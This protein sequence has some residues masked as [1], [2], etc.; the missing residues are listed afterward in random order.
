MS[1]PRAASVALVLVAALALASP[2]ADAQQ[3]PAGAPLVLTR[4]TRAV[5]IDGVPDDAG[6]RDVAPLPLTE[7]TPVFRGTPQQRSVIK[8]AYD[9]ENFYA[10][11]WFYDTDPSQIRIN[12][13]YRDRWNGDDAFAIYIDPFNDNQNAKWFGTTASGIRFDILLSDDAKTSNGS[14]DTF[15]TNATTVTDSG[16]FAE[17]RIPLSSIGFRTNANGEAVMGLTVTRQVTRSGERVTFPAIDSKF[18]FRQPSKAQDV[19]LRDVRARKPVYVTPYVLTGA[20]QRAIADPAAGFRT[21]RSTSHEAGLDVKYPFSAGLTL[22]LTLNT[23]FAQVEADDQQ[24][25]LDRFP[26]YFPERR[27]FFQEGSGIFDFPTG[28][29]TLL[30]NSRRI[31]LT[32]DLE[33]VRVLG[34]ARVVGRAGPWDLGVLDM[35]TAQHAAT[36]SENFGVL[37]MRRRVL[38]PFSTAG[39][40]LTS[41]SGASRHNEVIGADATV[42]VHGDQYVAAKLAT[43]IDDADTSSAKTFDRSLLDLK[44][45]RRVQRGLQYQAQ[46]THSGRDYNPELG[47]MPRRDFTMA[48]IAGN[49]FIFTSDKSMFRRVFPGALSFS[50]FRNADHALESGTSAFWLQWDTKAGGGGWIEPKRFHENVTTPFTIGKGI[51]IPAGIYDFADL[52]LFLTMSSGARLRSGLDFRTGT[53]FDGRRTQ[54]IIT[55]TWNVSPHLE[56]GTDYQITALHFANRGQSEDIQLARLRVIG[57]LDTRKSGNAVIQYNSTTGHLDFNVRLR[58][59]FAEGTDLWLV[60]DEGLG[61]DRLRDADGVRPPMSLA[62][63]M[64][65]K[66]SHTVTF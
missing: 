5:I 60:Y 6:W 34:G 24:V 47:F 65:V 13:L 32:P 63:T 36:P 42:R 46:V 37:R 22:D 29:G 10:A 59:A 17:V 31:G 12:S 25:N 61:T 3:Q 51:A 18:D 66:Y 54:A 50:T 7:Y 44:I 35:Q 30:F 33:P 55:P 40:M 26:L 21:D 1:T 38:N 19:V 45:E 8:V 62:R 2:P 20:D 28:N 53:Y 52:Q 4:L 43:S 49:W 57:A 39:F 48:N 16:W 27:R 64:I 11:G 14:W 58:Y 23:D 41:Y 9:D 15:W 56:L